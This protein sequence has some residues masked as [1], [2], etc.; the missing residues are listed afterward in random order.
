M[1][2]REALEQLKLDEVRFIPCRVSPHKLDHPPASA[3]DRLKMLHLATEAFPWAKVDDSELCHASPSYSYMTAERIRSELPE[4]KLFWL[5]GTDQ[6]RSLPSWKEAERLS[7]LLEFIV[8]RRGAAAE[9]RDGWKMTSIEG[10][11][12]AS[13]SAIREAIRIQQPTHDWLSPA[14][15]A[16]IDEHQLYCN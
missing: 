14:V 3:E 13:S 11:H 9:P 16:Y 5:V 1:I 2:A 12:P 10:N 15:E 7:K 4:A 8:F 6:W